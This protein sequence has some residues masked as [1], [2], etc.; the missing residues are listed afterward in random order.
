MQFEKTIPILFSTDVRRSLTYYKEV[1]CFEDDWCYDVEGSFGG[2]S[3]GGTEIFFC[4]KNQGHP[5]TWICIVL[6]DVD[7]YFKTIKA[8]GA[9]I[10]IEPVSRE[11]NMRE[12]YVEDPDGHI[13]RFGQ[14]INSD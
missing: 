8:K 3:K 6:D 1:L 4:L 14:R 12:M 10:I 5:G 7:S 9:K 11:W 13:I 2:T